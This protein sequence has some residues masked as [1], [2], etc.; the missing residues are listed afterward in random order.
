MEQSHCDLCNSK[1]SVEVPYSR[2]YTGKFPFYIC[3]NCGLIHSKNRKTTKENL[4][5]WDK[6]LYT[7]KELTKDTYTSNNPWIKA[8]ITFTNEFTNDKLNLKDKNVCDI[9]AGEG[10]FLKMC[11]E[12][13]AKVFGIEPSRNNCNLLDKMNIP[14]FCGSIEEFQE[15]KISEL[16]KQKFL[17]YDEKEFS[18]KRELFACEKAQALPQ[19]DIVTIMWTLEN[20][21]DPNK[22]LEKAYKMLKPNG[23]LVYSAGSRILVPFKKP[24]NLFLAPIQHTTHPLWFSFNTLTSL[25][26]KHGFKTVFYNSYID[27]DILCVISQKVKEKKILK[28]DN[29]KEVADFFE[30]WHKE[31]AHYR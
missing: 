31:S 23:Y 15:S 18:K 9:G 27:N 6:K 3:K 5:T 17:K 25:L 24:L 30:R 16:Q 29:Y 8:R 4:D 22:M 21:T 10:L 14:N 28:G 12:K 1:E 11:K 7:T 2:I 13:G 19:F 26:S 20:T